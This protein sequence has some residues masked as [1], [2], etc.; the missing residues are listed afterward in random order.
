MHFSRTRYMSA[1]HC[2]HSFFIKDRSEY[3]IPISCTSYKT[4]P[5]LSTVRYGINITSRSKNDFDI[6][7]IENRERL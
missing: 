5:Y 2:A 4:R 1:S 7:S 6:T 3:A